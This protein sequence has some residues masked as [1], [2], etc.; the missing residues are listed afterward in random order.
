MKNKQMQKRLEKSFRRF[1]KRDRK[2]DN[3]YLLVYSEKFGLDLKI[4]EGATGEMEAHPDQVY[5]ISDIYKTFTSVIIALL[6]QDGKISYEDTI[7][8]YLDDE[9]IEEL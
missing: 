4:A 1:V 3:A 8:T 7:D 6:E 5:Y 2:I 9:I